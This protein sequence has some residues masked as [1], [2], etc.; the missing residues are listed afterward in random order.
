MPKNFLLH[1]ILLISAVSGVFFWLNSSLEPF[2][3]QL[4]AILVLLY[5]ATHYL[6]NHRP[7]WFGRSTVTIDITILTAMTLLLITETGSLASPFFFLCYF[8]LFGV[9]M[10]YEIEATLVLTSVFIIFFLFIPGTD[11]TG[12]EGLIHLT[13]IISLVM[14]TPLAIFTGHQY[15][16]SLAEKQA[17]RILSKHLSNQETDTL[18]FLSLNL[19]K[20]LLSAL[21]SLSLAIPQAKVSDLRSNLQILYSDLKHLYRSADELQQTI[22]KETDQ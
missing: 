3:L 8:L 6:R 9:A 16:T 10:L 2:T 18:L 14:I 13:Q 20:T 19:K 7:K 22:D 1:T 15:E 5:F 21:D 12:T 11:L 17:K 4:V